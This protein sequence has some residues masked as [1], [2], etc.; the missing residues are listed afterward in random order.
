MHLQ[1]VPC[2]SRYRDIA[3]GADSRYVVTVAKFA[4]CALRHVYAEQRRSARSTEALQIGPVAALAQQIE[5]DTVIQLGP[6]LA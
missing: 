1:F 2:P 4:Y 6:G 5:P 3:G